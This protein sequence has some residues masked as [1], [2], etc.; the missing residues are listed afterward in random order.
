LL[1]KTSNITNAIALFIKATTFAGK[2]T[3]IIGKCNINYSDLII[4]FINYKTVFPRKLNIMPRTNN[5]KTSV[6]PDAMV[7]KNVYVD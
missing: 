4:N 6:Y 2:L 3:Y 5:A 1:K 7:L